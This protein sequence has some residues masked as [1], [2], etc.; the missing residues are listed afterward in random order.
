MK[1]LLLFIVGCLSVSSILAKPIVDI[2]VYGI[3]SKQ[4]EEIKTRY[5]QQIRNIEFAINSAIE[6]SIKK[7]ITSKT[8][9]LDNIKPPH[10]Y[11]QLK[12]KREA[13]LN[14]IKKEQNLLFVDASTIFYMPKN[15]AYTTI[16]VVSRA[17]PELLRYTSPHIRPKKSHTPS[18]LIDKMYEFDHLSMMLYSNNE[19][20]EKDTSSKNCPVYHCV[21]NFSHP[22]LKPYLSLFNEGVIKEKSLILNTLKNDPDQERRGSAVFLLGHLKDPHEII[23]RLLPYVQDKDSLVRNNSMR[24]IGETMRK[25]KIYDIDLKPF[26]ALLH[27]PI[28]LD[29]NKSLYVLNAAARLPVA[30]KIIAQQSGEVLLQLLQLK[31]PNNHDLTY[32]LLKRISNKK[33]KDQDVAAW[34]QWLTSVKTVA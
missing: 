25:A 20:E 16:E 23:S 18:D 19:L 28:T 24:V 9:Q 5:G 1:A 6:S 2:D 31:Q 10:G 13:L 11:N 21:M 34:K 8:L 17:H 7:A 30:Q 14:Q 32:K 4:A 15:V 3:D 12:K 26:L 22:R 27:S 29:R 33:W